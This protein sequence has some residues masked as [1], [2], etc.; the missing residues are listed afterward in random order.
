MLLYDR[1]RTREVL[2]IFLQLLGAREDGERSRA[3]V[4]PTCLL[5]RLNERFK[6]RCRFWWGAWLCYGFCGGTR[7][8]ER[9]DEG[10]EVVV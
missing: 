7:G 2:L 10:L 1:R 9:G 6:E 5:F 4:S 8:G 3:L